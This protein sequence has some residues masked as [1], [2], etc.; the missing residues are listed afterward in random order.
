MTDS[1]TKT[2]KT[3]LRRAHNRGTYDKDVVHA[4]IDAGL[5]C[6]VGYVIDGQPFVTPTI[7]W[8]EGERLYWHGSAA[9]Q[10]LKAQKAGIPV[11][12]TISHLDGLVL[13]RSGLH[14]SVNYRS[15]M[16]FGTAEV[17]E[18]REA[19]EHHLDGLMERIVPGRKDQVR[20][21]TMQEV[22]GTTV[23]GM[24]LDE[25]VAKVRDGGVVDDEPDYDL[26]VWA[27][28]LPI[29]QEVGK[30]IPDPR[31]KKGIRVPANLKKFKIG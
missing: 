18:G 1:Y 16:A 29:T 14:H 22:K 5:L 25:V 6:H 30:P 15:V 31:L 4:I 10:A 19:K 23:L 11:C 2:P 7:H 17:V 26:D 9:S 21:N 20:P 3:K 8:R 27:G 13:A 12:V 24:T 28:V